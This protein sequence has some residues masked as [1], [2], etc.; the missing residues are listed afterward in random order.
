MRQQYGI[1]IGE[2]TG[3]ELKLA[4]GSAL[5][6][7]DEM[8]AE[9][10]G[11]EIVSGLPKTVVLS[12][13]EIRYALREQVE[14]IVATVVECLGESPPELA[15]DIIYEGI[16]LVGG[17]ACCGAWPTGWPTRP[18][19]RC[20]WWPR[21]S[22][23]WSSGPACASTPSTACAPSSPP[24]SPDPG[25]ESLPSG[26]S[27]SSATW[28]TCQSR[29]SRHRRRAASTR[30]LE[31]GQG[32]RCPSAHG[33][34]VVRGRRGRRGARPGRRWPRGRPRRPPGRAGRAWPEPG[35]ASA[36]RA[37]TDERSARSPNDHAVISTTEGSASSRPS[38]MATPGRVAASSLARRR[39]VGPGRPG[40]PRNR[41]RSRVPSRSR[42]P[43]GS[44]PH[45]R[46][47]VGE[48]RAGRGL[49][50]RWP[51]RATV[52]RRRSRDAGCRESRFRG[53]LRRRRRPA[54]DGRRAAAIGGI[55]SDHPTTMTEDH[56][57]MRP[58]PPVRT[59]GRPRRPATACRPGPASRGRAAVLVDAGR[60]RGAAPPGRRRGGVVGVGVFIVLVVAVVVASRWNLNYYALQPGHGPVGPA[61]HHRPADKSHPVTHPVLLTDVEIGRVTALTYLFYKLQGNTAL[62]PVEAVTGG[63]PPSQLTAQ[64]N[65]EM[66]QAEDDAKA[67]AL[68]D[69]ATR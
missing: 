66:S 45:R 19:C 40:R 50:P 38:A 57:H 1:A 31:R 56:D 26:Q 9:V 35:E 2:R 13:E 30:A 60:D 41:R 4:I 29:S 61:V 39:T 10:R 16:H 14:L 33:R 47:V 59:A 63:T 64:G 58:E 11:R 68:R 62:D 18:R 52:R 7:A 46:R 44:G 8:K 28:R 67:A 15:Q 27:R 69:S 37:G 53:R 24:P 23:A 42:A 12:P 20:T 49:V 25:P 22:S 55:W 48:A 34:L 54:H 5:P 51:A 3:E 65:L 21:R 36:D 17:G 43:E 6:Y 32:H